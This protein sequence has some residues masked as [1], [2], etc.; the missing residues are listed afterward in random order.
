MLQSLAELIIEKIF[1]AMYFD[2]Q[3]KQLNYN[4]KKKLNIC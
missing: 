2:D 3:I 4:S 1:Y